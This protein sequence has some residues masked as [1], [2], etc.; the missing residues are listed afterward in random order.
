MRRLF[1]IAACGAVFIPKC[2]CGSDICFGTSNGLQM[3]TTDHS[4]P[5]SPPV[6]EHHYD[7]QQHRYSQEE[8]DS[9]RSSRTGWGDEKHIGLGLFTQNQFGGGVVALADLTPSLFE[10]GGNA[11]FQLGRISVL[12]GLHRGE[13]G[14][15]GVAAV[16]QH[17][18]IPPQQQAGAAL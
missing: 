14:G 5:I 7:H 1:A 18:A 10:R 2:E 8:A 16:R 9:P 12:A 6:H 17:R 11:E 15:I 4:R 13:G 3:A